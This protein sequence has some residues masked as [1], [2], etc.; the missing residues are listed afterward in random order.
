MAGGRGATGA[1]QESGFRHRRWRM[2]RGDTLAQKARASERRG[3]AGRG[4]HSDRHY[5][6]ADHARTTLTDFRRMVHWECSARPGVVTRCKYSRL[7]W[8]ALSVLKRSLKKVSL[9]RVG[10]GSSVLECAIT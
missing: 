3:R 6:G 1:R 10:Y 5:G 9:P 7:G 2:P 4:I 8:G